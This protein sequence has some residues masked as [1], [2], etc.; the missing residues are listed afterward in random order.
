M[1]E[2]YKL[3]GE[4]K[5]YGENES[6]FVKYHDVETELEAEI[7]GCEMAKKAGLPIV[8]IEKINDSEK[9]IAFKKVDW[10]RLDQFARTNDNHKEHLDFVRLCGRWIAKLHQCHNTQERVNYSL[11]Q[12]RLIRLQNDLCAFQDIRSYTARKVIDQILETLTRY[13][14]LQPRA[15]YIHGDF[16]HQN[17]FCSSRKSAVIMFDWENSCYSDPIYDLSTFIS[18]FLIIAVKSDFYT[19]EDISLVEQVLLDTYSE[20][21]PLSELDMERYSFFK[22]LGHHCM[23]WYYLLV[24]QKF[25]QKFD[26]GRIE[27]FFE[28]NLDTIEVKELVSN[29]GEEGFRFKSSSFGNIYG[30]LRRSR[31]SILG[32]SEFP[33]IQIC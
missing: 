8:K 17:V 2:K 19:M 29:L 31:S 28:G 13:R 30:L 9:S 24:L 3:S 4:V 20:Q 33:S 23:Y 16:I 18:F 15:A 32:L 22:F 7:T 11:Q 1:S 5:K 25:S 26:D 10:P 27:R 14:S 6:L 12:E 21:I